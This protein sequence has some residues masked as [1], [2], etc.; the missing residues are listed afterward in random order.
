MKTTRTYS[1]LLAMMIVLLS[2]A[3]SVMGVAPTS[4]VMEKLASEGRLESFLERLHNAQD[5]GM[6]QPSEKT[7][8]VNLSASFDDN[9]VD[10]VHVLVLMV[11][12][13]DKPYQIGYKAGTAEQFDSILFSTG[14]VN[15][16]GSMTEYYLENSYGKFHIIG[17]I[18]GWFRMPEYYAYYADTLYGLGWFP[19]NSQGLALDAV[20]AAENAG[21][22]FSKYDISGPGG[23]PDGYVD[24]LFIIHA[25]TGHEESGDDGDIR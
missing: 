16:T 2:S 4:E 23:M 18:Y 25:G 21:V 15:P 10:T 3:S 6:D 19:N 12:F 13:Y 11:D 20:T 1:L 14:E 5:R 24:G 8:A 22:D 7:T 9:T 17:D